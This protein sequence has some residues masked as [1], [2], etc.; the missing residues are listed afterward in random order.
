MTYN[1]EAFAELK[2][3]ADEMPRDRFDMQHYNSEDECG[4]TRCWAGWAALDP[5]FNERMGSY[6]GWF[7]YAR[8]FCRILG[9]DGYEYA[10]LFMPSRY[11]S[12]TP[13]AKELKAHAD[14]VLSG[15]WN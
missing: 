7:D 8:S 6:L 14:T 13:T 5:Y 2:R 1:L 15:M 3:V 11:D 10:Y 9:I 12:F 4:T